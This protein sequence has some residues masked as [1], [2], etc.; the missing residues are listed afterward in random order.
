MNVNV[1]LLIQIYLDIRL[2]GNFHTDVTLC[3][4]I[5]GQKELDHDIFMSDHPQRFPISGVRYEFGIMLDIKLL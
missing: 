2:C 1:N 5:P 4:E 3:K